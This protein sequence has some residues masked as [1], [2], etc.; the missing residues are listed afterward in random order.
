MKKATLFSIVF[1]ISFYSFS[2]DLIKGPAAKNAKVW[3]SN[4]TDFNLV[5]DN[6]P[7]PYKGPSKKNHKVWNK[8]S[9]SLRVQTRKEINNPKGL[10]AKNQ[11]V[12]ESPE[13]ILDSKAAY[14]LPKSMRKKKFWWH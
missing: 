10:K 14:V 11:K 1:L 3:K 13:P 9:S 7:N 6:H 5:F 2:Q 4:F 8:E 12:W